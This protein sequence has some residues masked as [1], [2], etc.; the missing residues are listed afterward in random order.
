MKKIILIIILLLT[1]GCMFNSNSQ[2]T[3]KKYKITTG[4]LIKEVKVT[5][6]MDKTKL[7]DYIDEIKVLGTDEIVDLALVKDIEIIYN[8]NVR[9]YV[10]S[11]DMMFCYFEDEL[12][13]ISS[14]AYLP[15]GF[16]NWINEKLK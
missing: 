16:L 15:E 6:L 10:N 1:S 11:Q 3:I 14:L 4:E 9:V 5:K 2:I 13:G 7:E 8:E 12:N